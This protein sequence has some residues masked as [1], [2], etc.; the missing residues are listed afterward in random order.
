MFVIVTASADTY[1]TNK[2]V[3]SELVVSSN[4]GRAGTLDIFKLYDESTVITGAIELSRAL[5]TFDYGRLR[6]LSSSSLNLNNFSAKLK[7][8]SVNVGQPAPSNFTLSLFPLRSPFDEGLG[9]DVVSF[10]DVDNA[11]FISSSDTA[12]WYASGANSGSGLAA[13][14]V[15][16]FTSGNFGSSL[17]LHSFEKTQLFTLGNEDLSIDVTEFVS[18]SLV[19]LLSG[20]SFRLSFTGSQEDDTTSRFVK[21][22]ASRHVKNAF[23]RP[24]IEV[25]FDDSKIDDRGFASFNVSGNLYISNTVRGSRSNLVSGSSLA[26]ITGSNSLL[27]RLTTGSYSAYFTGSQDSSLQFITGVYYSP[28]IIAS[29]NST[30]VSGSITLANHITTSGSITFEEIWTSLDEKVVYRSGSLEMN[31]VD[32]VGQ[33][34]PEASLTV[35][36]S[37]PASAPANIIVLVRP[38]FFDLMIDENASKFAIARSPT[39]IIGNYRIVDVYSGQIYIDFNDT[40]TKLSLDSDGNFFEFYSDSI[41]FGRPV[42]IEY[43]VNY[44][45]GQKILSDNGYT[46]MLAI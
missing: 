9:R 45:G 40:G 15:D 22:F 35:K 5:L 33:I 32:A 14:N 30:V 38:K 46:F 29:N 10:S 25:F 12:A 16:Y 34:N 11:N 18:A 4:V 44:A 1:I 37:G 3:D 24:R 2:I 43:R 39:S 8:T 31:K 7:V 42:K 19:G 23:I 17:G 28:F 41:P 21:R 27:L 26:Q 36:T 13:Q 6:T 20:S